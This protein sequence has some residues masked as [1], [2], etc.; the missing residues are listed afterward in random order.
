MK[1]FI[2]ALWAEPPRPL[3]ND[4]HQKIALKN[5]LTDC[6]FHVVHGIGDTLDV[7]A[8]SDDT[9]WDIKII[10]KVLEKIEKS[11]YAWIGSK[12]K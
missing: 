3:W 1:T 10:E 6:G 4:E 8:I 7:Y 9:P 5:H 11:W 2:R 12:I